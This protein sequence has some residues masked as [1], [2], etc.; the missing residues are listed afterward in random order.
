[1]PESARRSYHDDV[2]GSWNWTR[3]ES[4][5]VRREPA[6]RPRAWLFHV[7]SCDAPMAPLAAACHVDEVDE[8]ALGRGE[9]GAATELDG[10]RRRLRLGFPDHVA[11]QSSPHR[12]S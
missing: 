3:S 10:G 7:F 6:S 12:P 8:V 2:K 1:M 4:M 5:H 9:L 11:R